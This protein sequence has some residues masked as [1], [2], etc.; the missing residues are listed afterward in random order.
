MIDKQ[1]DWPHQNLETPYN[2]WTERNGYELA[3][4]KRWKR[5]LL[6]LPDEKFFFLSFCSF[7]LY[8]LE[9]LESW[10][11]ALKQTTFI[12]E[13]ISGIARRRKKEWRGRKNKKNHTVRNV[14]F[15]HPE[16]LLFPSIFKVKFL[17]NDAAPT[18]ECS[19]RV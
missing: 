19:C 1:D 7:H 5:F 3:I 10:D 4:S 14:S 16:R 13:W 11:F 2:W 12:F 8:N 17:K 15:A 9:P 18:F 6:N